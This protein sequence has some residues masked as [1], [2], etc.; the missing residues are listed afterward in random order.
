MARLAT[1]NTPQPRRMSLRLNWG[2][3]PGCWFLIIKNIWFVRLCICFIMASWNSNSLAFNLLF[4]SSRWG[5]TIGAGNARS[6]AGSLTAKGCGPVSTIVYETWLS[7]LTGYPTTTLGRMK[8]YWSINASFF[9]HSISRSLS[10]L[11][12]SLADRLASTN[13]WGFL[14]RTPLNC[15]R[16]KDSLNEELF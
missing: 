9:L 16:L 8:I 4:T 15:S 6:G 7:Y 3:G 5:S 10:K 14:S 12:I 1:L 13:V 2:G 11:S